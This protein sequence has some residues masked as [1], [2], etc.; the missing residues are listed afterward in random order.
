MTVNEKPTKT[1]SGKTIDLAPGTN[2]VLVD[3]ETPFEKILEYDKEGKQI[4]FDILDFPE[5]SAVNLGRL[6]RQARAAYQMDLRNSIQTASRM[7]DGSDPFESQIKAI[8]KR[9]PLAR[10]QDTIRT[11]KAKKLPSGMTHLNVSP[12]DVEEL[13]RVGYRKAKPSEVDIVGSRTKEGAVVLLNPKGGVDNV[14]MLVDA[15]DYKKHRKAD[16]AKSEARVG[17]NIEATKEK[18]KRYDSRVTIFDESDL[19]RNR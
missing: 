3:T 9:D 15:E 2:Q 16:I 6:S 12:D 1:V 11:G 18:M 7:A 14:T 19:V 4:V 8:N 13:E 5:F 17:Q 10:S